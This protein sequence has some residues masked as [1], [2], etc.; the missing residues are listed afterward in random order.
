[1]KKAFCI[2]IIL[3]ILV[4]L[5]SVCLFYAF[6]DLTTRQYVALYCGMILTNIICYILIH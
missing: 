1:M 3:I 4:I 2:F 5:V 6:P